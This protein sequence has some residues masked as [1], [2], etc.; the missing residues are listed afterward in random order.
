MLTIKP[1]TTHQSITQ[2]LNI[3]NNHYY[4]SIYITPSPYTT[5]SNQ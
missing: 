4:K 2:K 1:K 5:K 3:Q